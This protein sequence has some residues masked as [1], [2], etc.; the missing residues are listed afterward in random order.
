MKR[1]QSLLASLATAT[2]I[3]VSVVGC[4]AL[5]DSNEAIIRI[6]ANQ[7][8][9]KAAR[10]TLQGV[11]ATQAGEI[12]RAVDR[13]MSAIKADE[14]YGPAHNNLGLLHYEQGN[15]YQAALAFEQAMEF[16]PHDPIAYY[17]LGLT[18]E[19]AGRTH[20][21]LDLYM[22]A[23]QMEPANPNFLG[24]LVRL[25][26]RL[27]EHGHD[28]LAQLRELVLIETRPKWRVWADHQLAMQ[29][30]DSLDRGPETPDFNSRDDRDEDSE[31]DSEPSNN[32]IDL[33]PESAKSN[34][35][36][37]SLRRNR[38]L[39]DMILSEPD[40]VPSPK[41]RR[42]NPPAATPIPIQDSNS[43]E[44]PPSIVTP[45]NR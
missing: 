39:S 15:L 17:N 37:N 40:I 6:Q 23:V 11:K 12:D 22:Q 32:I 26:I 4:A 7:D 35:A 42:S 38:K 44:L 45:I 16:M 14:T 30:N 13:F 9:S 29:F 21:A 5:T 36:S 1:R 19:A 25:R 24:N 10:L 41:V 3:A 20:E 28:V 33:T 2:S 43:F 18:L 34:S 31:E 27:G 8:P